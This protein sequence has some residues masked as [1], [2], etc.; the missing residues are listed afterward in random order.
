[1]ER[2]NSYNAGARTGL[3]KLTGI[4]STKLNEKQT[5]SAERAIEPTGFVDVDVQLVVEV[6]KFRELVVYHVHDEVQQ[7][8]ASIFPRPHLRHLHCATVIPTLG[9]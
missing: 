7:M 4:N 1:M 6:G 8:N 9:R 3:V 5:S 2:V